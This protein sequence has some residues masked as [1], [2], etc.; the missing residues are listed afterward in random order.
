MFYF[1]CFRD[2]TEGPGVE[3][4]LRERGKLT[5]PPYF[6]RAEGSLGC[7]LGFKIFFQTC[8]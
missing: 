3:Q 4:T 1:Y 5:Y 6:G 2:L 8:G 7:F